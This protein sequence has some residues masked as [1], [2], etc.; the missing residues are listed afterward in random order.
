MN[1][2]KFALLRTFTAAPH[3]AMCVVWYHRLH[4][5]HL[6]KEAQ[7]SLGAGCNACTALYQRKWYSTEHQTALQHYCAATLAV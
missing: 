6:I 1:L 3:R 2:G 7:H 5:G 4:T